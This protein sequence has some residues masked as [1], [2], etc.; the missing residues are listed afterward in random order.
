MTITELV[1]HAHENAV[2]HGFW[3]DVLEMQMFD[4]SEDI[5]KKYIN[6]IIGSS[7][8][9]TTSELGEALEELRHGNDKEFA[10]ELAD[11]II[12]ICDLAGFIGIDLEQVAIDK[13]EYNKSRPYK[14]GKAF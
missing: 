4:F 1:Q 3:D 8:M 12:R 7:L 14:H 6:R 9:L 13:M 2:E 5:R 10:V 11:A